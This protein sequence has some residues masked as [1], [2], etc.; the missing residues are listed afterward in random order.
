[1]ELLEQV[2]K[3]LESKINPKQIESYQRVVTAGLKIMFDKGTHHLMK[4]F[5]NEPGDLIENIAKGIAELANILVSQSK[6][7]VPSDALEA[8][9]I[10]LMLKALAYV[11]QTKGLKI[12]GKVIAQATMA[13]TTALKAKFQGAKETVPEQ[14][15][16]PQPTG[17]I[18]ARA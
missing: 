7:T 4:Q 18:G 2:E 15:P 16:T 1:M 11:E 14:P 12:D 9:S 5:I 17:L 3:G 6:G 13:T 10:A 8:A